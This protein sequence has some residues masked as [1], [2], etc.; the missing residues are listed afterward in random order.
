MLEA[1]QGI[2]IGAGQLQK[3]HAKLLRQQE[4]LEEGDPFLYEY[5][6]RRML[7]LRRPGSLDAD[8]IPPRRRPRR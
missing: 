7:N 4:A 2:H 1:V 3:Q 6:G 5:L 8:E